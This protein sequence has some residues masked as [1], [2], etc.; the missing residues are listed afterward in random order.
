MAA[1]VVAFAILSFLT[2]DLRLDAERIVERLASRNKASLF[3]WGS[4][5]IVAVF[6]L[7][8]G[9]RSADL[10][11]FDLNR[12][13]ALGTYFHSLLLF[14]VGLFALSRANDRRNKPFGW[15][16]MSW[17][18]WVM[19]IDELTSIHESIPRRLSIGHST[20][21]IFGFV[22]WTVLLAP[23]ILLVLAYFIKVSM[24]LSNRSRFLIIL[25][26]ACYVTAVALEQ[27]ILGPHIQTLQCVAEEGMEI[28]G[29][30]M[31]IV[32]FAINRGLPDRKPKSRLSPI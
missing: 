27:M 29:T 16:V 22:S 28:T 7:T 17:I 20:N 13:D 11:I 2:K 1:T 25:G 31:F 21:E 23:V 8:M 19:A 32:A 9:A 15:L 12:E 4:C 24:R 6:I 5:F 10:S 14:I 26:G 3:F 30:T 18:F